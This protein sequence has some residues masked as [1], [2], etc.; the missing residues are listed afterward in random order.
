MT[1]RSLLAGSALCALLFAAMPAPQAEAF[2]GTNPN[3]YRR[4]NI[5]NFRRP[6]GTLERYRWTK[7]GINRKGE[8]DRFTTG[9]GTLTNFERREQY[10]RETQLRRIQED[11]DA[12]P[13]TGERRRGR[14][15]WDRENRSGDTTIRRINEARR[16]GGIRLRR[17][18]ATLEQLKGLTPEQKAK[19]IEQYRESVRAAER[20]R[21]TPKSTSDCRKLLG[22]R[23]ARCLYELRN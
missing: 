15:F 19:R 11:L 5:Q 10:L 7:R 6:V 4:L 23:M 14:H 21:Y 16:G 12:R 20:N 13:F 8:D 22:R 17:V 2:A 1:V 9:S 3:A 18:T